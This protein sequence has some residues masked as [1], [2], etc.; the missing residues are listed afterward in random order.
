MIHHALRST[1]VFA[2]LAAA[3]ITARASAGAAPAI[4]ATSDSTLDRSG[5]LLITGTGFGAAPGQVS[6]GGLDAITT[7]WTSTEIHAYVPESAGPGNVGVQVVTAG[8]PSNTMPLN[9]T[10]RQPDER[11]RWRFQTDRYTPLQ[12]ITV[13]PDGTIYTSDLDN[14]YALSPDGGLLWAAP[15]AGGGRPIALAADGT[16]Y[17]GGGASVGVFDGI[18]LKS[19]NPDGSLRWQITSTPGGDLLTGP[20]IGPDGNIYAV[21]NSTVGEGL[22]TFAVDPAG[23]VQFSN[24]QFWSNAGGNSVITFGTDRFFA[25]WE[26]NPSGPLSIHALDMDNGNLLWDAGD[27]GVSALGLPIQDSL[28]R[29]MLSWAGT[30]TVAVTQDGDYDWITTHPGGSNSVLQPTMGPSGTAYAGKWLGVQLWA[31]DADGN[32]QWVSPD[33]ADHLHRICVAPDESMIV[34]MGTRGFGNPAWARGYDT[35]AGGLAWHLE[36]LP[37][38]G[39]N[40]SSA[41]TPVFTADAQTTYFT[42]HFVGS[43]ND[44]GYLYAVDVPF[45][46]ALDSDGDGYPDSFDNCPDV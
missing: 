42:T 44:Y 30:G 46:P 20:S 43:V 40:Q 7:T 26:L 39:V 25:S 24:V 6:I 22:G 36:L 31:F 3:A 9:V 4:S 5:R 2:I 21:Q 29:L 12:F 8:G 32:T 23:D 14:L 38:N 13:A 1:L 27:V 16:I 18:I 37:E 45:D 19:F 34:A 15:D 33:T 17:T 11:V 35:V 28:G 10:L 41:S